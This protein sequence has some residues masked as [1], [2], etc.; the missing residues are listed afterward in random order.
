M[1][2]V[3][4]RAG[5]GV[6]VVD[7]DVPEVGEGELLVEMR[8]CGVD[9]TDLEKAFGRPLTPPMLGHEVVGIVSE[10]RAEGF[11]KGDR[12]FVHHHVSCGKCYYC[13]E[14][15]PTM[16]PLF[17]KT[18]IEPCGFAEFFRVPRVNVE[19]GAVLRL[20]DALEWE[21]AVFIEPA[22]CVLRALRRAGFRAGKTLSLVG[23]GP[24]GSI[25]IVMAKAFGAPVV[26]VS[27]LSVFRRTKALENGADVAVNPFD[28]DFA[29]KCRELTDGL[30]VDIAVLAT[31]AYKP[32]STAL[33]SLRNGGTLLLFGA[34]EK[35]EK[36]E[37]DFSRLF[38]EEKNIVTS[39][40]TTETE[41]NTVLKMLAQKVFSLK[42][43]ITHVYP[44][45]EAVEAFEKAR[46][47]GASL[48]VVI[49]S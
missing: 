40:S 43:L 36:T 45:E 31:P 49:E 39:Y 26:A 15:S 14:G 33:D 12:V 21:E 19:R 2:A 37:V 28:T 35:G 13:R 47:A 23:A 3:K 1:K 7:V 8:M 4:V 25:F 42:H 32:L 41:T 9:G 27:E 48:K 29:K 17:L 24:T 11:E 6:E 16:C 18:S 38:I 5:G 30:G 34:P 46:D 22:A 44:I 20:P 10:S